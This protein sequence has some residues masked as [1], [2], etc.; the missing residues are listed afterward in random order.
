MKIELFFAKGHCKECV[1]CDEQNFSY[2]TCDNVWK[3]L[4]GKTRHCAGNSDTRFI[5]LKSVKEEIKKFSKCIG[6]ERVFCLVNGRGKIEG[7]S[8]FNTDFPVCVDF[9][10]KTWYY[11]MDGK[12]HK[13]HEYPSLFFTSEIKF[14]PL[15]KF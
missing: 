9:G 12:L 15:E 8:S 1:L 11:T 14:T 2:Q 13:S 4:F 6:G 7:V 10:K 3:V 5:L